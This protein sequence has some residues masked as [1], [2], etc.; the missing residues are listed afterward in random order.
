[1][2]LRCCDDLMAHVSQRNAVSLH[3]MNNTFYTRKATTEDLPSVIG[4][5]KKLA[6]FE[7]EP[8]AVTATLEVYQ[9]CFDSGL[10]DIKL[11]VVDGQVVGMTVSNEAFSTWKGKMFYLEDFY[12]L[13]EYRSLGIGQQLFD[14]FLEEAR[15]RNCQLAKWQV[16]D[17]NTDAIRFYRRNG[18][19][20]DDEWLNGKILMS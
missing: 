5:V 9:E 18:A 19:E 17:W 15:S 3:A 4:L 2:L 10:I 14:E 8:E 12:V 16:L 1:M 7:R 13:E 11:A 6:A 20:L